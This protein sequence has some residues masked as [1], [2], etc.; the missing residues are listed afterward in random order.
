MF[1]LQCSARC[2]P[3][4]QVRRVTCAQLQGDD[5]VMVEQ[6]LCD[7]ARKMTSQQNCT[8]SSCTGVWFSGPWGKVL[9][10]FEIM[11]GEQ[12]FR[13]II[14]KSFQTCSRSELNQTDQ[15]CDQFFGSSLH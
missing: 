15:T 14:F 10:L 5:L 4:V 13:D 7:S 2:G 1:F 12:F 8:G 3:G 9:K 11:D 6:T